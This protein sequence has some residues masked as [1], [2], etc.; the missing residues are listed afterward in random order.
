MTPPSL[1]HMSA[2][3]REDFD[4]P[5][6]RI[7]NPE[8]PPDIALV[9][10]VHGD[11]LNGVFVL[12]RLADY[13]HRVEAGKYAGLKLKGSFL[14]VPAVNVLGLNTRMRLWPFDKTDINRM[15]P[16]YDQGET[17]QRIAAAVLKATEP[18]KLRIE[19]RSSNQ[20]LEE[21][22]HLRIY[23]TDDAERKA[24][25]AF[26]LGTIL[27]KRI[28]KLL[29]VSLIQAW[30]NSGGLSFVLRAGRG[31]GLQLAYCERLFAALRSFLHHRGFLVDQHCPE[32]DANLLSY[33]PASAFRILS[34]QA[35]FFVS[36]L[37]PG[38]WL[39]AGDLVGI[40]Y[41]GYTGKVKGEVHAP[42]AGVVLGLRR[43]PLTFEGDMIAKILRS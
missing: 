25:E 14:I 15:F 37:N 19:L 8:G 26:G 3:L 12:G 24:A 18:A 16:G 17:T 33:K 29:T 21:M 6:H 7:G 1:L 31:G 28:D 41:D 40:L 35:G 2:P 10:G 36:H 11:E 5:F 42:V 13:L 9:G 34:E 43:Q 32:P 39:Q 27:E 20:D 38:Q 30:K 22:P 4:I 23:D